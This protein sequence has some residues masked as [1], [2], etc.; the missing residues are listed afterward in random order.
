MILIRV[1]GMLREMM[2]RLDVGACH[3]FEVDDVLHSKPHFGI[4]VQHHNMQ[5]A[6]GSTETQAHK[7]PLKLTLRENKQC[8]E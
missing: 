6:R 7:G 4:R 1:N 8:H 2:Q 5:G 3:R